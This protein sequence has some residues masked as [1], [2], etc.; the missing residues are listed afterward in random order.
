MNNKLKVIALISSLITFLLIHTMWGTGFISAGETS[1]GS[2]LLKIE[3]EKADYEGDPA[4]FDNKIKDILKENNLSCSF[5]SHNTENPMSIKINLNESNE[6]TDELEKIFRES[7]GDIISYDVEE[8]GI[9]ITPQQHGG[10]YLV[11]QLLP[12]E[13]CEIKPE[14]LDKTLEILEK[15]LEEIYLKNYTLKKDGEDILMVILPPHE[16]M[17]A[18]LNMLQKK[19]LLEIKEQSPENPD[20]WVTVLTGDKI[21]DVWVL[22]EDFPRVSFELTDEGAG[23]FAEITERNLNKPLAIYFDDKEVSAPVVQTV[24]NDGQCVIS[25]GSGED[26][27][28]TVEECKELGRFLRS[29]SLPVHIKIIERGDICQ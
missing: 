17:E 24:I 2:L 23:E 12:E 13:N 21:K 10:V 20:E 9:N 8:P 28:K 3:F 29:G 11:F 15:R 18:T 16:T 1:R 7:L 19:A 22:V 4:G 26:H 6:N 14:I 5:I 27:K 25:M